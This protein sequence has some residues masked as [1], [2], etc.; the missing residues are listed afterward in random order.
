MSIKSLILLNILILGFFFANKLFAIDAICNSQEY[1]LCFKEYDYKYKTNPNPLAGAAAQYANTC[2]IS[3]REST[4]YCTFGREKGVAGT[5]SITQSLGEATSGN[6]AGTGSGAIATSGS[7]ALAVPDYNACGSIAQ[8]GTTS[9]NSAGLVKC[10]TH[11]TK[12]AKLCPELSLA[13]GN[14]SAQA[15]QVSKAAGWLKPALIGAAVGAGAMALMGGKKG[16]GN[17]TPPPAPKP[18]DKLPDLKLNGST[19]SAAPA[20]SVVYYPPSNNNGSLGNPAVIGPTTS[21]S[22]PADTVKV[23]GITPSTSFASGQ[24]SSIS[25]DTSSRTISSSGAAAPASASSGGTGSTDSGG[26]VGGGGSD[27]ASLV[28]TSGKGAGGG[29][30]FSGGMDG[31]SG[32]SAQAASADGTMLTGIPGGKSDPQSAKVKALASKKAQV[33]QTQSSPPNSKPLARRRLATP[34]VKA[35]PPINLK[36]DMRSRGLIK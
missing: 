14:V 16:G 33:A 17:S 21:T 9:C 25:P 35:A 27:S 22:T 19:T 32:S 7:T 23:A 3:V 11:A 15:N 6:L 29:G 26:G 24:G 2:I 13:A 18:D 31:G 20:P 1:E 12:L 10:V 4:D 5:A 30:S 36:Q 34:S 28:D 8:K